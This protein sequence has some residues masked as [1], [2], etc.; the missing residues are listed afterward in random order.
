MTGNSRALLV[1]PGQMTIE[2]CE[3]PRARAGEVVVRVARVGL[4]GSDIHGFTH[5]PYIPP[6]P[7]QA[8]GLG[9]EPAGI[10]TEVGPG[11]E[12]LS[13]GDRVCVE[14]GRPCYTCEFC[15]DG[16]YNVCPQVDFM[17][18]APGY[19]GA[20]TR[21]L[22]HPANL[23]F[24]LPDELSLDDGAMVE[25]A[26]VA[27]HAVDMAGSL[28]GRTVVILGAGAVGLMT[29]MVARAAGAR[30]IV[31]VDVQP[32]RL[33]KA[34]ELGAGAVVD[35]RLEGPQEVAGRIKE[36]I[37]PYGADVVFETAGAVAAVQTGLEVVKRRGRLMVVGTVPGQVPVA[38]LGIN[39]EVTIQ[40]VFRYCNT[41]PRAIALIRAGSLD[42]AAVVD[43]HFD[44]AEVQQ[45]FEFAS[46][47]PEAF[48]KAVVV[49]DP[50][51][52]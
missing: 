4:C 37:G 7:G 1:R 49:V 8:V 17:A 22:S 30:E 39:R 45:A 32:S 36:V 29:V 3:L 11:V 28:L 31:V 25:P 12:H 27:L 6:P 13:M 21:F 15:L 26:S 19:R 44:Y 47:R 2:Q 16:H 34:L 52:S 35:G 40:T 41:Y 42:V 38:F 24:R 23:V 14:P 51:V 18:T 46:S 43:R 33:D 48:T 20:L 9:H 5:G 50:T 10:V